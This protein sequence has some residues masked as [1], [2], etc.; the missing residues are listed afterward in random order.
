MEGRTY[1]NTLEIL[2]LN[3]I[4]SLKRPCLGHNYQVVEDRASLFIFFHSQL[5]S[6]ARFVVINHPSEPK[7]AF[8]GL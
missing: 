2:Y 3:N 7:N 8:F 1:S 5:V 4:G 6:P